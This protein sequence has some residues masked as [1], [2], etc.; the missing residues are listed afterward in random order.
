L[1]Q[2]LHAL[3]LFSADLQRQVR[4]GTAQELPRLAEQISASTSLLGELLDSLLDIS[5]L[6]VAG[7]KPEAARRNCN[8]YSSAWPTPSAVPQPTAR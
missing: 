3:S 2:P 6:D 4:S 8:R 1:R 5:R 7:I